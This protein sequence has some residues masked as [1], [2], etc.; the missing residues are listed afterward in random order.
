MSAQVNLARQPVNPLMAQ[1]QARARQ[2]QRPPVSLTPIKPATPQV[3][4]QADPG[5][6]LAQ[7]DAALRQSVTTYRNSLVEVA[8]Y[9]RRIAKRNGWIELGY[10]DEE[11]YQE[12]LGLTRRTWKKY[13][14]L[15]MRLEYLTLQQMKGLT[16]QSASK[17]TEVHPQIWDEFS[18]VEE[19]TVLPTRDFSMLVEQ[20][21]SELGHQVIIDPKSRLT[22]EITRSQLAQTERRIATLR[23]QHRLPSAAATLTYALDA[24]ERERALASK[25]SG[26]EAAVAE[27]ARLWHNTHLAESAKEKEVRLEEG[28]PMSLTQAGTLS[29][30][31]IKK[32]LRQMEAINAALLSQAPDSAGAQSSQPG[33]ARSEV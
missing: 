8:Y 28:M 5:S 20:R 33:S 14:L 16:I 30:S 29:R 19:A 1:V 12:S 9:G 2:Q 22:I 25:V 26:L 10:R 7:L 21:N 4:A 11:A 27:L 23:K 15:G 6:D 13:L 3:N 18:W 31:M 17:L 32:I 24:A